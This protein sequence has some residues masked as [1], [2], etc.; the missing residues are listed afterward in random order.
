MLEEGAHHGVMSLVRCAH[1]RGPAFPGP[2]VHLDPGVLQQR[3]Y[4]LANTS[5]DFERRVQPVNSRAKYNFKCL[6]NILLVVKH[7]QL[8]LLPIYFYASRFC[9]VCIAVYKFLFKDDRVKK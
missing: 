4:H 1:E 8:N 5:S 2:E 3:R 7:V 9:K 6:L